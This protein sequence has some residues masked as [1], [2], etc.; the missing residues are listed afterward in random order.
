MQLT[1]NKENLRLFYKELVKPA[2]LERA[3][4]Y[5]LKDFE[6]NNESILNFLNNYKYCK[7]CDLFREKTEFVKHTYCN[8]C[9]KIKIVCQCNVLVNIKHY[10]RHIKSKSHI[11]K[12][13]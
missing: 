6:L 1:L 5:K 4:N 12:I 11:E 10:N 3:F 13:S 8:D 7:R 9:N 2:N